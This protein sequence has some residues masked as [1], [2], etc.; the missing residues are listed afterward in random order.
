[1][2]K[3]RF[4]VLLVI[5]VSS[6][7]YPQWKINLG[8]YSTIDDNAFRNYY[9]VSDIYQSFYANVS[10]DFS[11]EQSNIRVYFGGEKTAYKNYKD[12]NFFSQNGGFVFTRIFGKDHTTLNLGAKYAAIDYGSYYSLFDYRNLRVFGNIRYKVL[13][14][15]LING[16]SFDYVTYPALNS[17]NRIETTAFTKLQKF[18]QTKTTLQL[19]FQLGIN[20]YL[21]ADSYLGEDVVFENRSESAQ[22][23]SFEILTAQSLTDLMGISLSMYYSYPIGKSERYVF[24][25]S[26][27][28]SSDNEIFNDPYNF[29]SLDF[30]FQ[31]TKIFPKAVTLSLNLMNQN[32]SYLNQIPYDLDGIPVNSN[33]L[34]RDSRVVYTANIKKDID[35]KSMLF[36]EFSLGVS[37]VLIK[38]RSNDPYYN[39]T[40]SVTSLSLGISY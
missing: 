14:V 30:S 15:N 17:Q 37:T 13:G 26:D 25:N 32:K 38:N 35:L 40:N 16:V 24:L 4:F 5:L 6:S 34:R 10:R 36:K 23:Y 3:N 29:K 31:F 12:R 27:Y 22:K 11:S 1:M 21:N 9:A 18:F 7:A 20:K 39:Y 28:V 2:G 33:E 8:T 19:S